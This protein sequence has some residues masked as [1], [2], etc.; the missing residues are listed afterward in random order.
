MRGYLS[1]AQSHTGVIDLPCHDIFRDPRLPPEVV[2]GCY[3]Q[4]IPSFQH[5][6]QRGPIPLQ[7][8]TPMF[9]SLQLCHNNQTSLTER[10]C[11]IFIPGP[12]RIRDSV[13]NFFVKGGSTKNMVRNGGFP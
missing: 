13:D 11:N 2:V 9:P 1:R 8:S 3:T 12:R 6:W 5:I 4:H 7:F 10:I